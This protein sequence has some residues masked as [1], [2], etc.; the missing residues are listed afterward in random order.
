MA[1][2]L[3]HRGPDHGDAW[4]DERMGIALGHQRL[5]ILDLTEE[6][7][8][9]MHSADGR[10]VLVFNGEI[11][12]FEVL[13][14]NLQAKGHRFRGHSDT[15]VML[16]AVCEWG[17]EVALQQFIGMF[18]FALWD[19]H[20][21][22][23]HLARDRA[24]EKPLYYGWSGGALFFGSELKALRVYPRWEAEIDHGALALL[25]RY[26]YIP[27]PHCI[28]KKVFKLTPG[29]VLTINEKQTSVGTLPKPNTYWSLGAVARAGAR[30]PFDGDARE[31]REALRQLLRR[32][33]AQQMV[34]D[35]PVG[36]F[37]S[38]GID[39]STVVALMQEQSSRPIK[40]FSIGFDEEDFDEAPFGGAVARHLGTDHTQHY[41]QLK[42][43]KRAVERLPM[44]YDEPF[45]DVSQ[46]PTLLLCGL[47]RQQVTVSLSGDAGDEIFG[48]YDCYRKAQL[49]WRAIR[50][51]PARLRVR[52][53]DRLRRL[54]D[55]GSKG[56]AS[57]GRVTQARNRLFNFSLLLGAPDD[58]SLYQRLMSTCREP[59]PWLV[60]PAEPLTRFND[61]SE[62][63]SLP[64][65][66]QRMMS[67][68]FDTYLPDDILVKVDRAAMSVSLETRIPLLDHRIVEFA[69]SLPG[70]MK[71]RRH[72]GKWL[73]RQ[74]LYQDV[75]RV[76][77]ERPKKGFAVPIS[78]WLRGPLR[79]WAEEWLSET[80]LRREGFFHAPTVRQKW[81]EHLTGKRDWG[82]PLWTVLS[83]QAWLDQ[84][85]G[86]SVLRHDETKAWLRDEG[87]CEPH[88]QT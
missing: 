65:L 34:A 15:E 47:A 63:E 9:P 10:Y 80:R 36:A 62:W 87:V 73:L 53:A 16:A 26:G 86:S 68:D 12:N 27:A 8:Q 67:L 11:Y 17:I 54:C 23:L 43:V 21:Q 56:S 28:Y 58:Q 38:G 55:L 45:A 13:R 30:Q 78:E 60:Q 70:S 2:A 4:A 49:I 81:D 37:L 46:I 75:P 76:L 7:N 48:G 24:G 57:S 6:G 51:F 52:M 3:Q 84:Q 25:L 22:I 33:V 71:Q 59:E 77:V 41:I 61:S 18:A 20:Q 42:D 66:L 19:S 14:G 79:S 85:K 29:S 72:Q 40:T 32:S 83:F 39:S 88:L 1:V 31:A 5:A 69:C 82:Q 50:P 74:V 35:V 64:E 44:V